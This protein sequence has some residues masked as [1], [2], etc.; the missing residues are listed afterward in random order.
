[1]VGQCNAAA[2][3]STKGA[4]NTLSKNLAL[5]LAQYGIRV[6]N[7]C[8]GW[9]ETP[10]VNRWFALQSDEAAS[11]GY[12]YSIHPLGRIAIVDE[13][14][15]VALFL[16]SDVSSFVTGVNLPVNGG[17]TLGSNCRRIWKGVVGQ[18]DDK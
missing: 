4:S 13:I 11:R 9:A 3:A 10:L 16:A 5:D 17:V 1:M 6:N 12:I 8:P 7:I 2:Y 15:Q 14:G 18:G